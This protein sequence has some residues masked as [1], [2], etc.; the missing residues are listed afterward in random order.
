MNLSIGTTAMLLAGLLL[1]Y[2]AVK[3]RYPQDLLKEVIGKP[4]PKRAISEVAEE[5]PISNPT[6]IPGTP[7]VTV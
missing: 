2:A 5:V 1:M 7:I 3:N 4:P 6:P